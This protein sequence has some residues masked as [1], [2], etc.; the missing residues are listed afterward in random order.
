MKVVWTDGNNIFVVSKS[1]TSNKKITDGSNLV[2]TYTFSKDQWL[3]ATTSKGFGMKKFFALDSSNCL[4]CP[5][6]GNQGEGGCYTHKFNQ[7]VGFLSMLRSIKADSLTKMSNEKFT[8]II[9]M[10]VDTYVRFGTYGEPSLLSSLLVKEM[11]KASKSW[12]GYT[13]QWNKEWANSYGEYFMAS[14]HNQE[15][16]NKAKLKNYR[17]FIATK[18]GNEEAVTCPASAEAGFKSNCA[19]CGLCSGTLGK[20]NKDIKILEH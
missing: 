13:H 11:T 8:I 20:G 9:D 19:S 14:T 15:E 18:V 5:Y 17:S 6:S 7:Y 16:T 12:T 4:D 1:K 10:C 2:Q 3:L